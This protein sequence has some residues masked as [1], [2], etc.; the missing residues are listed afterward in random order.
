M[1]FEDKT[2][3]VTG[4][5]RGIGKAAAIKFAELGGRLVLSD[6]N[7]HNLEDTRRELESLGQKCFLYQLDVTD[8]NQIEN[9]VD[10]V[11]SELG[12]VDILFNN[13]GVTQHID[14]FDIDG[15]D[16]DRIHEVNARGAFFCMQKVAKLMVETGKGGRIINMGSI[17]GKGYRRASN[18]AYS[19]SKG[20]VIQ[21]TKSL[22]VAWAEKNIQVNAIIP[23]GF[24]TDLT[25]SIPTLDPTRYEKISNRIPTG[26]WGIPEDIAGTAVFLSSPGSDYI[27]GTSVIVDGGYSAS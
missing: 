12:S 21:L 11:K 26:K 16:W 1:T 18:A 15:D 5:G 8:L 10:F 4:A 25:A 22:A 3:L 19:A 24:E 2:I 14:F 7:T 6:V 13:A 9:M 27:T 20:A 17:A 23:G